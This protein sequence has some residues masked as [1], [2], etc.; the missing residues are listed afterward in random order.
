ME[1]YSFHIP[2]S[3]REFWAWQAILGVVEVERARKP[4]ESLLDLG[5]RFSLGSVGPWSVG[6][7]V[8]VVENRR[9]EIP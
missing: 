8:K 7:G 6:G 5:N 1:E 4:G 2:L 9:F 3:A